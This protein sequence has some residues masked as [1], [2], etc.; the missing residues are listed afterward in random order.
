MAD[1]A[2]QTQAHAAAPRVTTGP[3]RDLLANLARTEAVRPDA[4]LRAE[5]EPRLSSSRYAEFRRA[6]EPPAPE[7]AAAR[8]PAPQ[9]APV[10][11]PVPAP[12]R[13]P[14]WEPRVVAHEPP[15]RAAPGALQ[16]GPGTADVPSEAE[17]V[18]ALMA[19]NMM[20]KARLR[21]EGER[22][23]ELKRLLAEEMRTLRDHVQAEIDKV[24][25]LRAERDL[26]MARAEALAQP[27]FQKR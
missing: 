11:E 17:D 15:A 27:L 16:T 2:Y 4:G 9:H 13:T 14:A 24:E 19:E 21:V 26:W 10:P 12:E 8:A 23:D 18:A 20:L 25:D 6:A 22:Q 7:P 5:P 3:L 1:P